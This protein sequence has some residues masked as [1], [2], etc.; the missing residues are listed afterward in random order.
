MPT[1]VADV[2]TILAIDLGSVFTRAALFDVVNGQYH[3]IASASAPTTV[4]APFRDVSESVHVAL[5]Q[6]AEIT[7]RKFADEEHRLI[8]PS[9]SDNSG[10]DRL[11]VTYSCGPE[12]RIAVAGLLSD[13]SLESAR[14]L[15]ETLFGRVVEAIGLNDRRRSEAQLDAV[16]KARPDLVILAGGTEGGASRSIAKLVEL[17]IMV[18]RL[19]PQDKRPTVLYAGNQ[20]LAAKVKEVLSKWTTTYTTLNIRPTIDDEDLEPA[21]TTLNQVIGGIRMRQVGGLERLAASSSVAPLPFS[22]AFGRMIRFIGRVSESSKGVLGIDLGASHTL[23]AAVEEEKQY[24]KMLPLGM[25]RGIVNLLNESP[26]EN[27]MQWL[28]MHVAP[29]VVRDYLWNKSLYPSTIPLTQESLAIEQSAARHILR[30]ATQKLMTDYP[31]FYPAFEPIVVS[32]S[33]ISH[34]PNAAQ[35]LLLLLDGVQPVGIST[36]ILDPYHLLASLG[37]IAQVNAIAAVQLLE[38]NAFLNLGTIICPIST[39]KYGTPVLRVR[40]EYEKGSPNQLE[41]RQGSVVSLP[42]QPFQTANVH[43]DALHHSEIDP[44]F[45]KRSGSFKI[46]G[47]V[48]GAVIDARGRPLVLP[49]DAA[50]RRELIKKW[51]AALGG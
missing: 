47:G 22:Y 34:A 18:C 17:L 3:F 24:L 10:V 41:V 20:A 31:G 35:A 28:P 12:L 5:D 36:V 25:G 37:A 43:L 4:N 15:V 30:L 29:E 1:S 2:E 27:V 16:I 11:V 38:S 40:I 51:R 26:L 33:M 6:L 32:G 14:H 13:V 48:C 19:L 49:K 44:L 50:R 9:Q 45:G 8:L 23:F 21:R 46:V 7:G 39:A 42:L